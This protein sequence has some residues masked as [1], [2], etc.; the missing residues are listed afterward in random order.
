MF[1]LFSRFFGVL[2]LFA[3][4]ACSDDD[5]TTG[6]VTVNSAIISGIM[7]PA[8]GEPPVRR[9]RSLQY[10]GR[11][12]WSPAVDSGGTFA[13]GTVYTATITLTP[14]ENYT[15]TN[16]PA[17]FF[18]V[19]GAMD[20]SNSVDSGVVTARFRRTGL[21][22]PRRVQTDIKITNI[23]PVRGETPVTYYS[24]SQYS[25]RIIWSPAVTDTFAPS[26][27]YKATLYLVPHPGFTMRGVGFNSFRVEGASHLYNRKNSGVIT[28]NFSNTEFP[29]VDIVTIPLPLP[30]QG[31]VPVTNFSTSQYSGRVIWVPGGTDFFLGGVSYTAQIHLTAKPGYSLRG[32]PRNFFNIKGALAVT[33]AANSAF[34]Y[35]YLRSTP[36]G[37]LSFADINLVT[38]P[39]M[40]ESPVTNIVG[41]QYSGRV[42]WSPAVN[43]GG[44]FAA[45]TVYT[46]RIALTPEKMYTLEGI[47]GNFF[48]V[49][50]A[51]TTTTIVIASNSAI[52]TA[53]F[54]E[55]GASSPARVTLSNIENLTVPAGGATP[56]T[57]I[58]S[59]QYT[60]IV[61]WSP[62]HSRFRKRTVYRAHIYLT[63]KGGYTMNGLQDF[64]KVSGADVVLH[65]AD[66]G[67]VLARFPKTEAFTVSISRI[68]GISPVLSNTLPGSFSNEQ[69]T[70]TVTWSADTGT[71]QFSAIY[72][73]RITL[74]VNSPRYTLDGVPGNFFT[75]DG[76]QSVSYDSSTRTLYVDFLP[77]RP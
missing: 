9:L 28:A 23:L 15:L 74:T 30:V 49:A 67:Y 20:A 37:R 65:A 73:A 19:Y 59:A 26:T 3:F 39:A 10:S 22:S 8:M 34:V 12:S 68:E 58:A 16:V 24:N 18:E 38:P 27:V 5:S 51:T 61:V 35:A 36:P 75:V 21:L 47:S 13:A 44:T 40:G 29:L 63:A 64:F 53:K 57:T 46:A 6:P 54:P 17:N 72:S 66:S 25:G 2:M 77:L 70:G 1:T 11:V 56:V 71:F 14:E 52:V 48:K 7:P 69:Y 55:T 62:P 31:A 41:L 43:P 42:S 45:G 4:I 50:R 60:G 33:N 32:V 76:A